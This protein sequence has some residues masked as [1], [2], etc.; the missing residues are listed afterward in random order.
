MRALGH[1]A[2]SELDLWWGNLEPS[3]LS[4]EL[5]THQLILRL[6]RDWPPTFPPSSTVS[7]SPSNLSFNPYRIITMASDNGLTLTTIGCGMFANDDES[8]IRG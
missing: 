2:T 5:A 3:F 1:G 6:S 4:S 7:A 8:C